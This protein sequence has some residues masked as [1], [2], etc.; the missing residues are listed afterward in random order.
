MARV[1]F[2]PLITSVEGSLGSAT[3]QKSQ[4]GYI[5]RNKPIPRFSD[6][7]YRYQSMSYFRQVQK[8]WHDLS[9]SNRQKYI[10]YVKLRPTPTVH[11]SCLSLSAY[12][13]FLKYNIIRLQAGLDILE[14]IY[15][16]YTLDPRISPSVSYD[17]FE[18]LAFEFQ[19]GFAYTNKFA[20]IKLTR[21]VRKTQYNNS[22]LLRVFPAPH[23]HPTQYWVI[24]DKYLA[25]FHDYPA[26]GSTILCSYL[27]FH[28]YA[29]FFLSAQ[30]EYLT[31]QEG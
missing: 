22:S 2:S 1:V 27:V 30:H 14:S 26:V 25:C 18:V 12:T 13:L 21:P 9:D 3:F 17:G 28:R 24:Q 31:V 8:A 20:L 15:F 4:G 10:N 29:P 6:S 16:D 19:Y 7:F 11:N 5:L 23:A